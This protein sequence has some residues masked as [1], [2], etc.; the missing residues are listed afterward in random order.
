MAA[1][2][3]SS[4]PPD[5][6]ASGDAVYAL[7]LAA[8]H[9][10]RLG[11]PKGL[12]MWRRRP[13]L[14]HVLAAVASSSVAGGVL[15]L[16][17][18][19]PEIRRAVTLPD[20][21]TTVTNREHASGQA[22]SLRHGLGA[23]GDHAGAAV[24]LL[25][26]QPTVSAASIDAVVAAWRQGRGPVVRIRYRDAP[27]HPV[28]LDRSVWPDLADLDGDVGARALLERRPDLLAEVEADDDAPPDIDTWADYR[29]FVSR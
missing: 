6:P 2:S 9:A 11:R 21:V 12:L 27:G 15:V 18:A 23:L 1:A 5:Q 16:G 17:H 26:D 19:A 8:G 4:A 3:S 22:S 28:L 20:A 24:V 25:A 10:T 29:A 13:L 7:V 14:E